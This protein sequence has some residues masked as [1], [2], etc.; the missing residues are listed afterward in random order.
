MRRA[1]LSSST[2]GVECGQI[3]FVAAVLSVV[4]LA[5][6]VS[7]GL[8]VERY[9]PRMAPYAIG[10]LSAFWFFQRLARF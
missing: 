3:A 10:T 6:R 8:R 4:A 7:L 9:V 5:R 1:G 2:S